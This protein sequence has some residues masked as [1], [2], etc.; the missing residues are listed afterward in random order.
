MTPI[1]I[2]LPSKVVEIECAVAA[3]I[4][5]RPRFFFWVFFA[6][7]LI[8][9]AR[10]IWPTRSLSKLIFDHGALFAHN[11]AEGLNG[12]GEPNVTAGNGW[13]IAL[14]GYDAIAA[15]V[16]SRR[17]SLRIKALSSGPPSSSVKA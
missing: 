3:A 13:W 17:H 2:T 5:V 14:A 15:I 4:V 10:M 7:M 11:L 9:I 8:P 1:L 6:A 16:A 12:D